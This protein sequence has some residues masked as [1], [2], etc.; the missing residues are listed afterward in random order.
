MILISLI[1]EQPVPNLLPIL[2]LQPAK[3][4]FVYSDRT[5][6]AA[7]R[8]R[9]LL[10]AGCEWEPL[11]VDA[12]AVEETRQALLDHV[13]RA[14][15]TPGDITF[16][17]TGGTKPMSLAAY[18]AA[19][20]LQAPWIY[21]Q[22]EGKQ[23]RLY[24]Y[25]FDAD[26]A[27]SAPATELLPDLLNI[28]MYLRS[29]VT[30]Y[31]ETGFA[32]SEEGRRFEEAVHDALKPPVVDEVK[33]GVKLLGV[34]DLDLVVRCGNQVGIIEA[35]AG[36]S[37]KPGI[38]QLSTAGEQRYLGTYT[39]K[40]L[41]LGKRWNPTETNLRKLANAQRVTVIELPS[42]DAATGQ[43]SAEDRIYLAQMVCERLGRKLA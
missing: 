23:S 27:A 18:L 24:R 21:L 11:P 22:T 33:V 1:G 42:Y 31:Q 17:L 40:L 36:K 15:W 8:L 5:K 14:G 39:E 35:K 32:K 10:P 43:L 28:D 29:F 4:V 34:V 19:A 20:H 2:Y 30:E 7:E 38:D 9:R 16:N 37:V 25:T 3:N 13:Q 41:I 6:A 26:G 12:Y